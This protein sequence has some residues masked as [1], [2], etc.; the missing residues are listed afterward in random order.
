MPVLPTEEEIYDEVKAAI[1]ADPSTSLT[2]FSP[3]AV[4]DV[5][6][7]SVAVAV[8][9][10]MRWIFKLTK[11]A[12]VSTAENTDLDFIIADILGDVLPRLPGE[13]DDAYRARYYSYILALA[14]GTLQAW[15][16]FLNHEVDGVDTID[17]VIEED[18]EDGIVTLT[19]S[20]LPTSDEAT[21]LANALAALPAWRILGGPAVNVVTEP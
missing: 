14:R 13:S 3:G 6:T 20:P 18:L 12:F 15:Q 19:I 8:R 16:H 2:D 17:F 1:I 5:M 9:A 11:T 21:I 10:I 4:L 7:G